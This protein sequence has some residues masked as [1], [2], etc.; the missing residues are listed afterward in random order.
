[1]QELPEALTLAAQY[2]DTV[3]GRRICSAEA[4]HTPHGFAF[5]WGDPQAYGDLLTG[6][7]LE[8][9]HAHGMFVT[10]HAGDMCIIAGDGARAR[11]FAPGEALPDRHQL[12]I[13]LDDGAAIVW[14]IQMYGMLW[15]HPGQPMDNQY[16]RIA[17]EKP[18]P[19]TEAFDQPY[20]ESIV[21]AASPK[22]SAKALLATEQR[23]P[24]LGNGTLQDILY[25]T[26]I[27]PKRKVGELTD[28]Q[29]SQLYLGVKELLA[30]MTALGGRDTER[31][32][33]G[34]PGGYIT[35]LSSKTWQQP[36]LQCGGAITRQAYM[37]GNV[38]FCATCQPLS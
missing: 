38:Y 23:I 25:R 27:H 5:Y 24:G 2:R 7:V 35:R 21:R 13:T 33:F 6:Q 9:A 37:G 19:L 31:S 14:T 34:K 10:L 36:C 12:C 22:L 16:Y 17:C 3:R 30:E 4:N 26:G 32:L 1:M 20:F 11:Y 18:S 28:A 8:D 29:L 15:A